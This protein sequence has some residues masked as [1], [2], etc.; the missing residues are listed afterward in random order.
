MFSEAVGCWW[1]AY[2]GVGC[3]WWLGQLVGSLGSCLLEMLMLLLLVEC[4][5]I[6][7]V[8]SLL[9]MLMVL[10]PGEPILQF[11]LRE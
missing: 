11:R 6:S 10:L 5:S 3:A 1:A 2:R 4:L 7:S 8:S 9:E